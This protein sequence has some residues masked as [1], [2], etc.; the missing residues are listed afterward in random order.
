MQNI[1]DLISRCRTEAARVADLGQWPKWQRSAESLERSLVGRIPTEEQTAP[2]FD[3]GVA[4]CLG[5]IP[6]CMQALSAG[7]HASYTEARVQ[8][9]REEI[10]DLDPDSETC[11]WLAACSVCEEGERTVADFL[12]QLERFERLQRDPDAR[13]VAARSALEEKMSSFT[14]ID[15]IPFVIHDGGL[16]ASYIAGHGWGVQYAEAFGLFF[17]GTYLPS[18]GLEDFEFSDRV[19]DQGRPMSGP[20]HGSRQFVKVSSLIELA[21]AVRVVRSHL[22]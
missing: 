10:R 13:L 20:V 5:R 9:V 3:A 8:Q 19:D 16:Q 6:E 7:L 14:L 18:L 4:C 22:G 12:A 2:G 17:I 21:R 11:W 15:E 1:N